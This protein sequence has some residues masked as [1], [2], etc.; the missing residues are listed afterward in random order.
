MCG[1]TAFIGNGNS[2]EYCI[3][4]LKQLQNRGYD[5]AG[6]CSIINNSFVNTKFA[7][8]DRETAISKLEQDV[9]KE[10]YNG[11]CISIGHTRWA[12]HGPKTD[13][14]SHPHISYDGKFCIVH[15]GIIEN[16]NTLKDTLD[17]ITFVSQTDTEVIVHLIAYHYEKEKNIKRSIQ[18]TL[19]MIHGTWALVIIC[20]DEPNVMYVTRHGSPILIGQEKDYVCITSEQCGFCNK[21]NNYFVLD[22]YD[23][24]SIQYDKEIRLLTNKTYVNNNVNQEIV[25][26]SPN[27]YPHWMLKE[28]CEQSQTCMKTLCFGGRIS[29]NNQV[30][31]GGLELKQHILEQVEHIIL[32]GCGTSYHACMIGKRVLDDI[33]GF[34]TVQCFDGSDF[35]K[36]NIPRKGKTAFILLSQS[37][38]TMD[39]YRC[40]QIGKDNDVIMIGIVN[41]V[42]SLIAREVD[43]GC[44]MYAGREVS[45]ASTKSFTS[46]VILLYLISIW[47]AQIK[48]INYVKRIKYIQDLRNLNLDIEKCTNMQIDDKILDLFENQNSCFILGK[49]T[50]E[51]IAKEGALKIKE[52]SYIHAEGYSTSHLKHGPFALLHKGF[53]VIMIAPNNECIEKNINAYEEIKSRH[54]NIVIIT[55]N[56]NNAFPKENMITIPSNNS[57]QD[58]LSIIPL[59]LL[60]YKLALRKGLNPDFPRNLAKVVTVE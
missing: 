60:A 24:C 1:I 47:F 43:C 7:S 58:L 28:I 55:N 20:I 50:G 30:K 29:N 22:D 32:L 57:F 31:F 13:I 53:P 33:G 9:I 35:C 38:E 51:A 23:I 27:P 59:Q 46:Q 44:Y 8:T 6:I 34:D 39:L 10:K 36:D 21:V 2:F 42:N 26:L 49:N 15:N 18:K 14:N 3:E 54:A 56:N 40:I 45:V 25:D 17:N 4:S 12:T 37:G 52:V 41:V 11:S 48:E 19:D 5:S 16:F